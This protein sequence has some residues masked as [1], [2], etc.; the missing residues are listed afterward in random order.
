MKNYQECNISYHFRVRLGRVLK[1]MLE[2]ESQEVHRPVLDHL[3][4]LSKNDSVE[5]I[6]EILS[7]GCVRNY[8]KQHYISNK[9][10]I[11]DVL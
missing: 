3:C 2:D 7:V 5:N 8:L 10:F 6:K 11:G 9:Q 1:R 4:R